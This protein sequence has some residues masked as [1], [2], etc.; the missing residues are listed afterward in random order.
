MLIFSYKRLIYRQTPSEF[1]FI[2]YKAGWAGTGLIQCLSGYQ[3]I[4]GVLNI[5]RY[6]KERNAEKFINIPMLLRHAGSFGLYL[7]TTLIMCFFMIWYTY[8]PDPV[9]WNTYVTS[10]IYYEIGS[11]IS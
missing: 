5:R 8:F 1:F 7:V 9:T 6:F 10:K 2:F 4:D 11:I 3:L